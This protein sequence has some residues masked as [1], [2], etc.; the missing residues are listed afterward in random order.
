MI[1]PTMGFNYGGEQFHIA[2]HS[3]D[4]ILLGSQRFDSALK[5]RGQSGALS[6]ELNFDTYRKPTSG[7]GL[8]V[9]LTMGYYHRLSPGHIRFEDEEGR[10]FRKM[11]FTNGGMFSAGLKIGLGTFSVQQ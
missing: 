9:G 11:S 10:L 8:V 2:S 6:F 4:F 5:S 1:Y 7:P 3:E